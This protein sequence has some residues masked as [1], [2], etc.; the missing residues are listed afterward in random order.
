MGSV[1]ARGNKL[2]LAFIDYEGK[3][4]LRASGY[5][6]GQEDAARKLLAK[7]EE[8]VRR[9]RIRTLE[10]PAPEHSPWPEWLDLPFQV[11]EVHPEWVYF[12]GVRRLSRIKIGR[13]ACFWKRLASLRLSSPA[14]LT[15]LALL[16]CENSSTVEESA[17]H[18]FRHLRDHGEWFNAGEDLIAHIVNLRSA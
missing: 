9:H 8:R 15:V 12:V 10:P 3:R 6:V 2:W 14:A 5:V 1:Y 13:T 11:E 4:R 18:A 16:N 17:H 7:V